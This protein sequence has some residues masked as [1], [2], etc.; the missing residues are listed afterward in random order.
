MKE[1]TYLTDEQIKLL[2]QSKISGR[3]VSDDINSTNTIQT[4][5]SIK[6][7]VNQSI[8]MKPDIVVNNAQPQNINQLWLDTSE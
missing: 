7:F 5:E 3:E 6:N 8:L 4:S 2:N 1:R